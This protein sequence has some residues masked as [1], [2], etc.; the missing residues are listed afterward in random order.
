MT[1]LISFA[2]FILGSILLLPKIAFSQINTFK[3]EQIDSLQKTG[4]KNIVIF[5]HTDWC[6]YCQSMKYTTFKNKDIVNL[7]NNH[8]YFID[9]NAEEKSSI[10]FNNH[11]F[12]YKQ[13]GANTGIHELAEQL[14]TMDGNVSYPV[15][16]VLN[17]DF[18]II[19]QYNEFLSSPNLNKILHKIISTYE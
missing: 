8:F 12:H 17:P 18:E 7:L 19:F 15:L 10:H 1:K 2:I 3:F 6:G 14:G 11:T 4:K 5:I 13:T 9:F 16:C